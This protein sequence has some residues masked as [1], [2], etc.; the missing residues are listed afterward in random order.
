MSILFSNKKIE[1]KTREMKFGTLDGLVLGEEGRCRKELFLPS[2]YKIKKG[3]NE[4]IGIGK[5][6]TGKPRIVEDYSDDIY[7][8][9]DTKYAYTRVYNGYIYVSNKE[10]FELIDS[11][12]GADGEAG[13]IGHW[14]V[15]LLK[16]TDASKDLLVQICYS[17]TKNSERS[18]LLIQNKNITEFENIK[19]FKEWLEAG[20]KIGIEIPNEDWDEED[21]LKNVC[22]KGWRLDVYDDYKNKWYSIF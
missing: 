16:V 10:T 12:T 13:S 6:K 3:I 14:S 17:G 8:I 9:I 1:L 19:G 20:N 22:R 5:T 7:L 21:P 4:N 11:A 2:K 15:Y 18:I